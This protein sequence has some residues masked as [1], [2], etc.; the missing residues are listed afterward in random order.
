MLKRAQIERITK[1]NEGPR[2]SPPQEVYVRQM[3]SVILRK[4]V[5][6]KY[7]DYSPIKIP[8]SLLGLTMH[9]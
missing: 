2:L 8:L 6:L 1:S 4:G 5:E 7:K 3:T 9:P